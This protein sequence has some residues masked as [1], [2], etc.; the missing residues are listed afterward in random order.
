MAKNLTREIHGLYGKLTAMTEVLHETQ[1]LDRPSL[2][3]LA[4]YASINYETL[5]TARRSGRLSNINEV[6]L[7][8]AVGFNQEDVVWVDTSV[9]PSRR[10]QAEGLDYPGK[11]TVSEFRHLLRSAHGVPVDHF[12]RLVSHRPELL[13]SN[14]AVLDVSDSAQ[15]TESGQAVQLFLSAIL[16]P[17]YH[18]SGLSFGFCRIRFR[19]VFNPESRAQINNRL[20]MISIANANLSVRGGSH[21]PEWSLAVSKGVL[22]GE[23]LT[24]DPLCDLQGFTLGEAFSAELSVRP[25]DGALR[26]APCGGELPSIEKKV[27]I[28]QLFAE[29]LKEN[30]DSQ[31]WLALGI[32]R[33]RVVRADQL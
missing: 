22:Q 31:G 23:Y 20:G 11:D 30:M 32:Q 26:A 21:F 28:E 3:C 6:K 24:H 10:S 17:G 15:Q 7:A 25:T 13:D 33:L 9:A 2:E 19:L 8:E 5:K 12:V 1:Q 4:Q 27:I 18:E 16:E 29:R 14:L